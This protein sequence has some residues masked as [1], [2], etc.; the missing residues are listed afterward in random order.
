MTTGK[1]PAKRQQKKK[2]WSRL[3]SWLHLWLGLSSGIIV[4][5]VSL[6]GTMFVFCDNII[7]G[8]A[9]NKA[10]Y[11]QEVKQK[12]LSPEELLVAF[13]R[14]QPERKAFYF[15]TYKDPKRS[16]KIGSA[17]KD[18]KF[19][20]AWLD[21]YTGKI[22]GSGKA[23]YFFYVVAH[24][25][26]GEMPFGETGSLI[27]QIATWIF[28]IELIT[29]LVL[30][31]PARWT[32]V[33]RQQSFGIKWKASFKRVNYDLHNVPG[34]YSLLPALMLTVTGLIIVNKSLNKTTHNL[35]DSEPNPYAGLRK[36]S[37]PLDSTRPF[38][39]LEPVVKS[40]FA[41]G[42]NMNQVRM[43]I[44]AND[45]VTSFMAMA[46][47]EIGLKG[48]S[49]NGKM[50]LIDRYSGQQAQ[51]PPAIMKGLKVDG[52]IMNLHIGF[53][54]GIWGKIATFIIGLICTSLPI[55]GFLIW[56]GRR[57]KKTVKA[58]PRMQYA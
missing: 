31:W 1:V 40:L 13:K 5:I 29:G 8:L 46:A 23:Y 43:A 51:I 6:T 25:H 16:F 10:L 38:V 48:I 18:K 4:F 53:W 22:L 49:G 15:V 19:E 26:S 57:N 9:G 52:V 35:F 11:V 12:R 50:F 55:T 39:P 32:R 28:L 36:L 58:K 14:Q 34:F 56:L 7:D 42:E 54:G 44:P 33:T 3:N 20:F 41:S 30:W 17:G 2:W 21:P 24:V 27:V 45:S 47:E 37:A